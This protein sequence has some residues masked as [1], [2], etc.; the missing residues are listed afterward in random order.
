M[1]TRRPGMR[2]LPFFGYSLLTVMV[3]PPLLLDETLVTVDPRELLRT[4]LP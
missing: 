2:V 4:L 3:V 1:E